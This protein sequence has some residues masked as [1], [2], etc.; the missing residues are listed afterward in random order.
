[1]GMRPFKEDICGNWKK[2]LKIKIF[3]WFLNRKELLTKDNLTKRRWTGCKKCVFCDMDKSVEHL[4][5]SC[6]FSRD[7]WRLVH[8]TFNINPPSS[9]SHMFESWLNGIDKVTKTHVRIGIAA[10]LWAIWNCRNDIVFNKSYSTHYLS[11]II[12]KVI[13]WIQ[14]WSLLIPVDRRGFMDIGCT[15]MMTVVRAI[16]CWAGWQ[17]PRRLNI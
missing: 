3:L 15:H 16:F 6:T 9:V 2:K 1:M 10:I 8:F 17:H 4:F 13:Y 11:V 14:M 5:I 12:N 7:I